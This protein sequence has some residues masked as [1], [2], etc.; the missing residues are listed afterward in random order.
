M[1]YVVQGGGLFPHLTAG[2]NA[3]L[4][5]RHLGWEEARLQTTRGGAPVLS[6]RPIR[7]V[8][9]HENAGCPAYPSTSLLP[10]LRRKAHHPC[11]DARVSDQRPTTS[12]PC[13]K[14]EMPP[15]ALTIMARPIRLAATAARERAPCAEGLDEV[16]TM[17]P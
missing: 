8:I 16:R 13:L 1:G 5:A 2:D 3:A 6:V 14:T 7:L 9:G 4:L 12:F 15:S 17:A 11:M 10:S